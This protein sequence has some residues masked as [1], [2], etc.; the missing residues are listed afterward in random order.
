MKK[1][2][3]PN[4]DRLLG[5]TA[6]LLSLCT[7]VVFFYQ[8]NLI[9]KQ[10][11]MSVYPYL[12]V[13]HSGMN[14]LKYNFSIENKGIGPAIIETIKIGKNGELKLQDFVDFLS[15]EKNEK[16]KL[17][18]TFSNLYGGKLISEKENIELLK[19][20]DTVISTSERLYDILKPENM[21]F[22]IVY[23]S[24]Y[25]EKWKITNKSNIPIKLD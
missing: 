24:I 5:L 12:E 16:E 18:I 20:Q 1:I 14:T 15:A 10:Q 22:E 4:T 21:E 11:Y 23:S 8:T 3:L 6:I 17:N 13:G 9:R 25:G 2:K 19:S 7:L